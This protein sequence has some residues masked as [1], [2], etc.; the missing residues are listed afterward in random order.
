[1][2]KYFWVYQTNNGKFK[3]ARD[4]GTPYRETFPTDSIRKG[5]ETTLDELYNHL[6]KL[7]SI[8]Q[9]EYNIDDYDIDN[10]VYG[11]E[12]LIRFG[13]SQYIIKNNPHISLD[14]R[15]NRGT[16]G[17]EFYIRMSINQET[18]PE[19]IN[20]EGIKRMGSLP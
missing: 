8:A 13:V 14:V 4:S 16:G 18:L 17:I 9:Y 11:Q 6:D 7:E 19:T 2:Y 20:D 3:D 15:L 12:F 10:Q 5:I 1:M